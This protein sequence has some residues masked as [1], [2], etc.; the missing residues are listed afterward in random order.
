MKYDVLA[1]GDYYLDLI[2]SGLEAPP[3]LGKE[4]FSREFTMLPGGTYNSVATLHRLGVN[5]AWAVDFGNDTFSQYVREM[6]REEGLD[7]VCFALKESPLRNITVASSYRG[8]RQFISFSDPRRIKPDY[9]KRVFSTECRILFFSGLYRGRWLSLASGHFKKGGA[10][11]VMDGNSSLGTLEDRDIQRAL[12]QVDVFMPN[13]SEARRLT[14]KSSIEDCL[15]VLGGCTPTVIIKA[16]AEGAYAIQ[17]GKVLHE[18]CLPVK[19]IETTGAGDCFDAGFM[20][21][22]LNNLE[23]ADCLQWG[24]IVGG[25]S[26]QALG[27]TGYRVTS[28]DVEKYQKKYYRGS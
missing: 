14:G 11:L 20:K 19:C 27:G 3:E 12:R 2:F 9:L 15:T 23:L 1:L 26:T 28:A 18:P 10:I 24:N 7:P 13:A 21:A 5:V 16:G 22:Y 25:L 8:D 6:A 17:A 4:V